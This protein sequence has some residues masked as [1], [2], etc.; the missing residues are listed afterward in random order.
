MEGERGFLKG[1]ALALGRPE[2][3]KDRG[4]FTI[5]QGEV[6]YFGRNP[7]ETALWS[8][9]TFGKKRAVV[10]GDP[11]LKSDKGPALSRCAVR[12][13]LA[14]KGIRVEKEG[15]WRGESG[16]NRVWIWY[17]GRGGWNK[18]ALKFLLDPAQ[19]SIRLFHELFVH[20]SCCVLGRVCVA[21]INIGAS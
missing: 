18:A 21:P 17:Q 15:G 9:F 12:I 10:F 16:S 7:Q 19:L 5:R 3:V 6:V 1:I 20:G 2:V 11:R 8:E 14:D 13:A 4:K